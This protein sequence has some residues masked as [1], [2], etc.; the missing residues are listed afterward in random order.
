MNINNWNKGAK[1]TQLII[2]T[3]P[4][5]EWPINWVHFLTRG[6]EALNRWWCSPKTSL[7]IMP[8]WRTKV[9][10]IMQHSILPYWRKDLCLF[11]N[12][13]DIQS[14]TDKLTFDIYTATITLLQNNNPWSWS[15]CV[16]WGLWLGSSSSVGQRNQS[17]HQGWLQ[18]EGQG[19]WI[20]DFQVYICSFFGFQI[21]SYYLYILWLNCIEW[22]HN[23]EE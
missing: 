6:S 21:Y 2:L 18:M 11:S 16:W 1:V 15:V 20:D 13:H 4:L 9:D 12:V 22:I 7:S 23:V 5:A 8:L 3:R 17:L 10:L 19:E 14:M